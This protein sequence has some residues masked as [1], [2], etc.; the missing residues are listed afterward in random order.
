M[1]IGA[2]GRMTQWVAA[3]GAVVALTA[4]SSG[5][6]ALFDGKTLKGWTLL[7]CEAAVDQGDLR[8]K[9]GNGLVQSEGKYGDFV[10]ELDW[11]P[12]KASEWD[13]GIYIRY[14]TVPEGQPWPSHYQANLRQG[15]EGNLSGLKGAKSKGLIKPGQWNHFKLTVRGAHVE[16]EINGQP[17]WKADGLRGPRKGYIALQ[18]EVPNGGQHR[19]RNINLTVL[20]PD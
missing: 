15:E 5:P 2:L 17:A 6:V 18:A 3:A 11:K 10:L 13:S 1:K 12:L 16:L 8:I 20:D 9:A 14:D 4:A 7:N 19:F